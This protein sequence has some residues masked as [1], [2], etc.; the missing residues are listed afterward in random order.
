MNREKSLLFR[1]LCARENQCNKNKMT[2][3][4]ANKIKKELLAAS[5]VAKCKVC[6]QIIE[7]LSGWSS[8][9]YTLEQK[10]HF[11]DLCQA[12]DFEAATAYFVNTMLP[13]L[14]KGA[15]TDYHSELILR[16]SNLVTTHDIA[17]NSK[18][19]IDQALIDSN[20]YG[21]LKG[22]HIFIRKARFTTGID[23]V[24]YLLWELARRP[25]DEI[26]AGVKR[27]VLHLLA[28]FEAS[29]IRKPR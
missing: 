9:Y 14:K 25:K 5:E 12:K 18:D 28:Q 6:R 7:E 10:N 19:I 27:C 8:K 1:F 2:T 15:P 23:N 20:Y 13:M 11:L 3:A 26:P 16:K 4:E 22:L 21:I 29:Q 24:L 17:P